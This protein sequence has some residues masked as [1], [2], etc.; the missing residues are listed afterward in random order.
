MITGR[1]VLALV[2]FAAPVVA[3]AA[4]APAEFAGHAD[5]QLTGEGPWFRL[6]LPMAV[7]LAARTSDLRDLRVFN[8]DGEALPHSVR[9]VAPPSL[10]WSDPL[11]GQGADGEFVWTLPLALPLARVRVAVVEPDTLAPVT[12]LGRADERSPWVTRARGVLHRLQVDGRESVA[13]ELALTG[14]PTRELKLEVDDRG[15]GLG[16]S[17]PALAVAVS[18]VEVVFLARGRGPHTL[19]VGGGD[20][21]AASLP[22]STLIPGYDPARAPTLGLAALAGPLELAPPPAPPADPTPPAAEPVAWRRFGLWG[23][24]IL[25]VLLLAWMAVSLLRSMPKKP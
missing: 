8:A 14:A 9:A 22:L 24:L 1:F 3:A 23:V 11:A 10:V 13:E 4:P 7:L 6:E 21:A 5:L 17:A 2:V 15:A 19:A 16:R 20:V 25:A 18:G 12:L